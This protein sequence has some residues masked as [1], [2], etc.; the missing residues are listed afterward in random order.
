MKVLNMKTLSARYRQAKKMELSE[1]KISSGFNNLDHIISNFKKGQIT[2]LCA[3]PSV[4]KTT[5]SINLLSNILKQLDK[6]EFVM[7]YSLDMTELDIFE[8]LV[9]LEKNK[10]SDLDEKE[11]ISQIESYPLFIFD[12]TD[13]TKITPSIIQQG[14]ASVVNDGKYTIPKMIVI[15]YFQS[16]SN[17]QAFSTETEKLSNISRD[18]KMVARATQAHFLVLAQLN[19]TADIKKQGIYSFADIK[20]TG[21]VEQDADIIA[22]LYAINSSSVFLNQIPMILEIA[23]NRNGA[24][25]KV[26]FIFSPNK[27]I[28]KERD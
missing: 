4:G 12:T 26:E 20:G 8:K 7:F 14:I 15:D 19:R 9:I 28:F 25:G 6:K 10:N 17:D 2:Y 16:L 13:G 27:Q 5:L 23:K 18:L 22:F 21:A 1:N 24:L 3:R 11:I